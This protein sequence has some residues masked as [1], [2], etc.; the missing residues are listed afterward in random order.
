MS[1][2]TLTKYYWFYRIGLRCYRRVPKELQ[3]KVVETFASQSCRNSE[4]FLF[5]TNMKVLG[6]GMKVISYSVLKKSMNILID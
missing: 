3:E 2:Q 1:Y 5:L 6:A 4:Q